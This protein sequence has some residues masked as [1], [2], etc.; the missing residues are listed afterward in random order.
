M[1]ETGISRKLNTG[2]LP[3]LEAK[4][5]LAQSIADI[6]T[7]PIGTRVM[8]PDYGSSL[9]RL[10]DQPMNKSWKLRVFTAC[11]EALDKWEPRIS[12][13][14]CAIDS[15]SAGAATISVTYKIIETGETVTTP[16]TIGRTA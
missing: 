13:T 7:T 12:L 1:M 15:V 4:N 9:P 10:I 16:V 5:H 11:A 14:S 6:L 3:I 8:R 2:R